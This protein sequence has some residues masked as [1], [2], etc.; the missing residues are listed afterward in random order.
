MLSLKSRFLCVTRG[1]PQGHAVV[2][3]ALAGGWRTVVEDVAVMAAA[4]DT[5][6][7]GARENQLVIRFV[8]E[9]T[10]NR[11]EKTRPSSAA[12]VLHVGCKERQIATDANEYTWPLFVIQKAR[13][14]GFSP[15]LAQ[16]IELRGIK[17]LA[18]LLFRQLERFGGQRYFH[19][20]GKQSFPVLLQV[21][22]IFHRRRL[23]GIQASLQHRPDTDRQKQLQRFTS[24]HNSLLALTRTDSETSSHRY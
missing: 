21:F 24:R 10:G 14:G 22:D 6:I 13:A 16:H 23:R 20:V 4:A 11:D 18:P 9:H 7:F 3:P 19:A 8:G 17:P 12:F 1:K 5:V 2:A 15:F